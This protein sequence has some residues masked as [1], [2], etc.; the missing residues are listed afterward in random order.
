M[1]SRLQH[2]S[3]YSTGKAA[4]PGSKPK[5]SRVALSRCLDAQP[6]CP[7]QLRLVHPRIVQHRLSK[8]NTIT[9]CQAYPKVTRKLVRGRHGD[10]E[11]WGCPGRFAGVG[12][13]TGGPGRRRGISRA[14]PGR[15]VTSAP[16]R[17]MTSARFR[18][19]MVFLLGSRLMTT[20][21]RTGN[22]H[23]RTSSRFGV[24][25][26]DVGSEPVGRGPGRIGYAARGA[27]GVEVKG[28]AVRRIERSWVHDSLRKQVGIPRRPKLSLRPGRSPPD[29]PSRTLPAPP[30]G[31]VLGPVG[32]GR[33]AVYRLVGPYEGISEA[34]AGCSG[35]GCPAAGSRWTRARAWRSTA[36]RKRTHRP[37]SW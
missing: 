8:I 36:V 34:T 9:I 5:S 18:P 29:R 14:S 7:A 15:A 11:R 2:Q 10:N 25:A 4:V 16:R 23:S 31:V 33:S 27:V 26:R 13:W 12:V 19:N 30:P 21:E 20:V 35:S 3:A 22:G 24:G 1:R 37:N 6:P 17:P 28:G 32:G